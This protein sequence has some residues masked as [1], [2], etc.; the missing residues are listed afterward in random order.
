[1]QLSNLIENLQAQLDELKVVSEANPELTTNDLIQPIRD[2][3]AKAVREQIWGIFDESGRAIGRNSPEAVKADAKHVVMKRFE[4]EDMPVFVTQ[5][6]RGNK[7]SPK[8]FIDENLAMTFDKDQRNYKYFT[9]LYSFLN[10]G[11][12]N[13]PLYAALNKEK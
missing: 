4:S 5:K 10:I 8:A 11:S 9:E 3:V 13:H 12:T 1:M 2:E 7:S 6:G